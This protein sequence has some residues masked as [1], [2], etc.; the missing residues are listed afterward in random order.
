VS[1][2]L[3]DATTEDIPQIISLGER[4]RQESL[5]WYPPIE[6]DYLTENLRKLFNHPDKYCCI[7]ATDGPNIV[8]WLS[9]FVSGYVFSPMQIA[10]HDV[11]YIAP[12]YRSFKTARGLV[13]AFVKW[14][15]ALG[16]TR[17]M[18]RLDTALRPDRVDR[19][20]RRL[21]FQPIGGQYLRDGGANF[22][23][24]GTGRAGLPSGRS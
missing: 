8:G 10:A 5:V 22:H 2:S 7:V 1:I 3:R 14:A 20:Y 24:S 13:L 12:E 21:G 6:G 9:G 18:I 23:H 16:I 17:Q 11:F 19:F 15:E 4:M